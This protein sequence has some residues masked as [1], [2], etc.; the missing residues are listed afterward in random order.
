MLSVYYSP[1][2]LLETCALIMV[3][4]DIKCE[5]PFWLNNLFYGRV[6]YGRIGFLLERSGNL[7]ILRKFCSL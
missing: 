1:V 3:S 4:S 7:V 2:G 6:R 5:N